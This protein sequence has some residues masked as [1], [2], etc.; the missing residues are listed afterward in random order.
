M[1]LSVGDAERKG[2]LLFNLIAGAVSWNVV[3][4]HVHCLLGEPRAAEELFVTGLEVARMGLRSSRR[5]SASS[6]NQERAEVF[7]QA[8]RLRSDIQFATSSSVAFTKL[9]EIQEQVCQRLFGFSDV[10]RRTR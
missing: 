10:I 6:S 4:A 2:D 1:T 5:D 7:E 3:P 8:H 9:S